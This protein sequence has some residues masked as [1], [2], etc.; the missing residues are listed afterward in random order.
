MGFLD[1]DIAKLVADALIGAGMSKPA[2][3]IKVTVGIRMPGAVSSGTNPTT[4]SHAAVGI[5]VDVH[6]LMLQGT[7]ITGADRVIRLFGARLPAGVVPAP[8][9]QLAMDGVTSVIVAG[10]VSVDPAQ[11]TFLCQCRT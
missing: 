6:T 1:G 9:D 11:A 10:G 3:L 8:G 5:P 2:T 4:V 7:L